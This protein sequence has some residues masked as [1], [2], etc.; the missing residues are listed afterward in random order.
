MIVVRANSGQLLTQKS[1]VGFG[2]GNSSKEGLQTE[3][4]DHHSLL[5][6]HSL[7][8]L[9]GYFKRQG[10]AV[11]SLGRNRIGACTSSNKNRTLG[12]LGTLYG[13]PVGKEPH[14]T[15]RF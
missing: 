3:Q 13:V 10:P 12:K 4:N 5:N 2:P 6:I 15:F 8:G 14:K 9:A 7:S 1:G 11:S